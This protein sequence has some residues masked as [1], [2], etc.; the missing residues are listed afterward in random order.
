MYPF[1]N[2]PVVDLRT[3]LVT[4]PWR[5]YLQRL[6]AVATTG[7]GGG[8]GAITEITGP[9]TA[10]PGPGSVPAT[11]TP[12]G[13][14]VGTYGDASHVGRFT[15]NAAGQLT[16]ALNVA[17]SGGGGGGASPSDPHYEP[18]TNGDP[19]NPELIF[20]GGGD[21]VMGWVS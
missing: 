2:H 15:V 14:V 19:I 4:P 11:I 10:G 7:G 3:G 21:V 13:V 17:I 12:T 6:T 5:A 1:P 16:A 8:G 20:D 18:V 9:V